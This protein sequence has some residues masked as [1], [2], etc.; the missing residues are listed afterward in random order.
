YETDTTR[1]FVRGSTLVAL[2]LPGPL[3]AVDAHRALG[4]DGVWGEPFHD[5]A[6]AHGRS[7]LWGAT[8]EDMPEERNRVVLDET[9]TD[10]D[11][12]PASKVH[13]RISDNTREILRFSLARMQELH[14]ASGAARTFA[15]ELWVDQPGHLLGTARMGEDPSGS[16]VDAYGRSHDVPNLFIAD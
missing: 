13:Y 6:K 10:G 8:A 12:I 3:N 1:G 4:F 2:P 9:L 16:V 5:A 15:N 11:G 7:I 14:E